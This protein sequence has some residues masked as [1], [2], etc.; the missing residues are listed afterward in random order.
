MIHH[1]VDMIWVFFY[2]FPCSFDSKSKNSYPRKCHLVVL[3]GRSWPTVRRSTVKT[4]S[5]SSRPYSLY[6]RLQRQISPWASTWRHLQEKNQKS[7]AESSSVSAENN[8]YHSLL[9][10]LVYIRLYVCI[11]RLI[12]SSRQDFICAGNCSFK[13]KTEIYFYLLWKRRPRRKGAFRGCSNRKAAH[14][15]CPCHRSPTLDLSAQTDRTA[16]SAEKPL[17]PKQTTAHSR[18][19]KWAR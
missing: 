15:F 6:Y 1:Y 4:L 7:W 2:S 14:S 12:R 13:L 16:G 17:W 3:W 10:A 18:T 11:W 19:C 5:G 8:P 9:Q